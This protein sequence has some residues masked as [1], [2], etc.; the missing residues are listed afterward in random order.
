MAEICNGRGLILQEPYTSRQER[1]LLGCFELQQCAVREAP[2]EQVDYQ[3]QPLQTSEVVEPEEQPPLPDDS[4][5]FYN[6]DLAGAPPP[7][8]KPSEK[9]CRPTKKKQTATFF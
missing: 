7:N 1:P 6:W 3:F 5:P 8:P 4:G 9:E 2:N